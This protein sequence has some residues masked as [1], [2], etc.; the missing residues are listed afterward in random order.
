MLFFLIFFY[1]SWISLN[2][3]EPFSS[4][5]HIKHQ[6]TNPGTS[7]LSVLGLKIC[8]LYSSCFC[9]IKLIGER[10]TSCLFFFFS[11]C[12]DNAVPLAFNKLLQSFFPG[13]CRDREGGMRLCN[14]ERWQLLCSVCLSCLTTRAVIK[15]R[16][17]EKG[18]ISPWMTDCARQPRTCSERV[19]PKQAASYADWS[20]Q[21]RG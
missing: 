6:L 12:T 14:L 5:Q 9:Q 2:Y 19:L 20:E 1:T 10:H 17:G 8:A 16:L 18:Q 4:C 11:W 13:L 3:S 15:R 7:L 21:P